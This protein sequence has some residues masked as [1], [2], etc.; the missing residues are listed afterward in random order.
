MQNIPYLVSIPSYQEALFFPLIITISSPY[1]ALSYLCWFSVNNQIFMKINVSTEHRCL[2]IS[3]PGELHV[4]FIDVLNYIF[5]L[6]QAKIW[7][8]LPIVVLG[9]KKSLSKVP[10]SHTLFK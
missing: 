5:W 2:L 4:M 10:A 9:S 1:V 6:S 8:N 3:C 7:E